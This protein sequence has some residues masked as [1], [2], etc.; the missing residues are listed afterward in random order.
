[1]GTICYSGDVDQDGI[2]DLT[3]MSLIFNDGLIFAS[4]YLPTDLNGDS[5]VDVG[6]AVFAD[7]NGFNFV[8]KITP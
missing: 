6:D 2:V 5:V 3:D 4:G 1:M 8:S 7:N